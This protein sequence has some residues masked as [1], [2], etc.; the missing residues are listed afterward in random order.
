MYDDV[1]GLGLAT[2]LASSPT[3]AAASLHSTHLPK[4]S[5]DVRLRP[6]RGQR[7]GPEVCFVIPSSFEELPSVPEKGEGEQLRLQQML[8]GP[9]PPSGEEP[10]DTSALS[11]GASH[12]PSRPEKA[13]SLPCPR[14]VLV[15]QLLCI[16]L[17]KNRSPPL[18]P[19]LP[20][21]CSSPSYFAFI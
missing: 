6:Y 21:P 15:A 7:R 20:L 17:R 16:S 11:D 13:L 3:A 12:H 4:P 10:E 19:P 2:Y 1:T 5:L 18:P 8:S 9:L 14:K